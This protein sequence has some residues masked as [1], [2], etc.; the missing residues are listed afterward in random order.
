MFS[1]SCRISETDSFRE[2]GPSLSTNTLLTE[3]SLTD[4]GGA[5]WAPSVFIKGADH[6][7]TTLA[8][9]AQVLPSQQELFIIIAYI[10]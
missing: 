4:C 10:M 2:P 7:G 5:G 6:E 3:I 1:Q 8:V 9:V